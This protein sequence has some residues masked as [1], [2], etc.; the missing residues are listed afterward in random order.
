MRKVINRTELL[1]L[2]TK[3]LCYKKMLLIWIQGGERKPTIQEKRHSL[4]VC[5][6]AKV[7]ETPAARSQLLSWHFH[8]CKQYERQNTYYQQRPL[9]WSWQVWEIHSSL[10]TNVFQVVWSTKWY[11]VQSV[12][13]YNNNQ[14]DDILCRVQLE[15][16]MIFSSTSLESKSAIGS[17]CRCAR[18]REPEFQGCWRN[19]PLQKT[20]VSAV[21]FGFCIA[22]I[23]LHS[24]LKPTTL[25][26]CNF[27][28]FSKGID[29]T[30]I[31]CYLSYRG[32]QGISGSAEWGLQVGN[33]WV[34]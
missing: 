12:L 1:S 3:Q 8:E 10:L 23:I 7:L 5:P 24:P 17:H 21:C 16:C 33:C 25:N 11:G 4:F 2:S 15:L 13:M 14:Q 32:C 6:E 26:V 20:E 34:P 30:S 19:R 18:A 29:W 22:S 9:R 27:L 31:R 28:R